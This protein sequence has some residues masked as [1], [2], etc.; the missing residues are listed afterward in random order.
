M[1]VRINLLG[2]KGARVVV[3]KDDTRGVFVPFDANEIKETEKSA[4]VWGSCFER[5]DSKFDE[6][7]TLARKNKDADKWTYFGALVEKKQQA[8]KEEF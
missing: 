3:S 2:L 4:N 1:Q 7:Y 8:E 6:I 5:R